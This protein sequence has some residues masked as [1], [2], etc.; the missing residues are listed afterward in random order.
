MAG[1]NHL[2]ATGA[3]QCG[4]ALFGVVVNVKLSR[5]R[6]LVGN[7][8]TALIH[9]AEHTRNLRKREFARDRIARSVML[10]AISTAGLTKL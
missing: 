6:W 3:D 5:G 1:S 7:T 10:D 4:K 9:H 8:H 2:A